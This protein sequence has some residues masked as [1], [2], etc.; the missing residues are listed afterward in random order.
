MLDE[1]LTAK[2]KPIVHHNMQSDLYRALL[3]V[4]EKAHQ[5]NVITPS[6][7]KEIT[8]KAMEHTGGIHN[9]IMGSF[10]SGKGDFRLHNVNAGETRF[11][12]YTKVQDLVENIA[13]I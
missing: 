13:M 5:K 4:V 3:L 9:T 8:A 2:D 12:D 6:L 10:D 11:V 1:N 7:V